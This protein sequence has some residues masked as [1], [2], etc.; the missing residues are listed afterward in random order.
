[1]G[2]ASRSL[3]TALWVAHSLAALREL[4]VRWSSLRVMV[5]KTESGEPAPSIIERRP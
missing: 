4:A 3:A 1:L 2:P 5:S